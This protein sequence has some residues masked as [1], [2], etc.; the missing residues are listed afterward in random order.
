MAKD[1]KEKMSKEEM[2]AAANLKKEEAKAAAKEGAEAGKKEGKKKL[3]YIARA[4]KGKYLEKMGNVQLPEEEAK[5]RIEV[6][7]PLL[8]GL[9]QAKEHYTSVKEAT[10]LAVTH[11]EA[12][13][14]A[15]KAFAD[16]LCDTKFMKESP[17][18][19]ALPQFSEAYAQL[20]RFHQEFL[21]TVKTDI[22]EPVDAMVKKINDCRSNKEAY[23]ESQ[24]KYDFALSKLRD[25]SKKLEAAEDEEKKA[26]AQEAFVAAQGAFVEA[27]TV[28]RKLEGEVA[29]QIAAVLSEKVAHDIDFLA[30]IM[31]AISDRATKSKA[32]LEPLQ[33]EI[34]AIPAPEP[35]MLQAA[36]APKAYIIDETAI[37]AAA[38]GVEPPASE[39][40]PPA[41]E[42]G[43]D[44]EPA[45]TPEPDVD[46]MA[47]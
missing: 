35:P 25:A 6:M 26:K 24:Q 1:K 41:P 10:R 9:K 15:Q 47:I 11:T 44:D 37:A 22:V 38:A 45:P 33:P 32:I 17:M 8:D 34:D 28:Y 3:G 14:V 39:D 46:Q 30:A 5:R 27:E 43:G 13:T 7:R 4:A 40:E 42:R 23:Y 21:T 19:P 20:D 18:A 2:K 36:A 31:K 29:E 12:S 16:A